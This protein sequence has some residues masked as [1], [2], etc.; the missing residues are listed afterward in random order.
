MEYAILF[1]YLIGIAL[2]FLGLKKSPGWGQSVLDN[3]ALAILWPYFLLMVID[4]GFGHL[5]GKAEDLIFH[6]KE[7]QA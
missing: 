2:T 3:I 6:Y 4:W 5:I 7:Q 1:A